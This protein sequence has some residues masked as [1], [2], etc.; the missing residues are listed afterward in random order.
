MLPK[1]NPN[2]KQTFILISKKYPFLICSSQH[3]IYLKQPR[4]YSIG[5]K[6]IEKLKHKVM[7]SYGN[8]NIYTINQKLLTD[9]H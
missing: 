3:V 4:T 8:P 1:R 5:K 2:L 7:T 9:C 6:N